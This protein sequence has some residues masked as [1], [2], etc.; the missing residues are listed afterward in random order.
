MICH[1]DADAFFASVLQRKNPLLRG[2]PL[3]ATGM[4][5]G[6]VIAASY[7]AK[8]YGVK[9][10]MRLSEAKRLVPKPVIM[11][12]DFQEACVASEQLQDILNQACPLVQRYSVDEW[13]LD[14]NTLTGGLPSSL[15]IW[16][17][18]L[19]A[20]LHRS[21]GLT[22]SF[23]IASSKL[24]SK[25][26]SEYR[27]PAGITILY[28]NDIDGFLKDRPA[29][30]IP[31]IGRRR[32]LH[33]EAN[34][35]LTA[36]DISQ[37]NPAS[38]KQI[39]GKP[40]LDMQ[41]ELQGECLEPVSNIAVP[42][43]SISRCRSFYAT[44]DEE[45]LY[46]HLMAHLTR[47]VLKMRLQD[48]SCQRV[49]VWLRNDTYDKHLGH[50]FKLPQPVATESELL[51]YLR[52]CFLQSYVA[53]QAYT[54]VGLGLMDLRPQTLPQYSLFQSPLQLAKCEK[55]QTALDNVHQRYGRDAVVR[56]SAISIQLKNKDIRHPT[57]YG[58]V[59]SCS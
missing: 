13:F 46:A 34:R 36:W 37:A 44:R 47:T 9:T 11:P 30:A 54:Q 53:G 10:G 28:R 58:E 18:T 43:K 41:R 8:A 45:T 49:T 57:M 55:I 16:A 52:R 25:I 39:F 17:Q 1:I 3:L 7:E 31:G 26:A 50:D 59:L 2:K 20:K 40:G 48:L 6:C 38:L 21:T 12:S 33:A 4:G 24:L 19:Q 15:S 35:W 32:A 27:K 14:L 51:P 29:E 42:P 5:G 56:G 22:C 23:G